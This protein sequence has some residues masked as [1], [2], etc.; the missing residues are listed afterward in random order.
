VLLLSFTS[1]DSGVAASHRALGILHLGKLMNSSDEHE[2]FE[3]SE[4]LRMMEEFDGQ[5][6]AL[7]AE[8]RI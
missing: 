3:A 1:R 5:P 4:C 7:V 2:Q 8:M 6:V